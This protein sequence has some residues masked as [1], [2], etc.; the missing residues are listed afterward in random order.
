MAGPIYKLWMAN[1]TEA[2]YQLSEEEK[3]NVLAKMNEA[4]EEVGVKSIVSCRSQWCTEEWQGFGVQEFP[5]IETVQRHT[6]LLNEMDWLRY[7]DS[8]S[9]LGTEW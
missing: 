7:V 5:D 6:E 1:W 4:G 2:W 3:S 9:I 8:A